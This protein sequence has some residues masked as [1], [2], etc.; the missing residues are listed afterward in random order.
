MLT[1][2]LFYPTFSYCVCIFQTN[3]LNMKKKSESRSSK[4]KSDRLN[5]DTTDAA[6]RSN[7]PQVSMSSETRSSKTK[8]DR[9]NLD[10]TDSALVSN[11]PQVSISM[12]TRS[13]KTKS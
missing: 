8:T 13:S 5:L 6:P 3:H 2:S 11:S 4:T 1:L 12:G 9:L 10:T 7:S